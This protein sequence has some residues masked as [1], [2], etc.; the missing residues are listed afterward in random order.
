MTSP[1]PPLS[2]PLN[3]F[4]SSSQLKS[5]RQELRSEVHIRTSKGRAETI[6]HAFRKVIV[7]QP[8]VLDSGVDK[9]S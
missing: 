9:Q 3:N 4:L 8:E 7:I 1:T 5:S 6:F 2:L